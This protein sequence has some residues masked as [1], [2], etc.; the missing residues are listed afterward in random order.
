MNLKVDN[1]NYQERETERKKLKKTAQSLRDLCNVIMCIN[2]HCEN[3][4]W[5]RE[6]SKRISE[7]IIAKNFPNLHG[8]KHSRRLM[9][10]KMNSKR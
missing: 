7:E 8:Y 5:K 4:R 2:M 1:E 10:Y 6:R 3:S 9:N